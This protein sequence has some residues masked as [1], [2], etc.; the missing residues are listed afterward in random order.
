MSEIK[1]VSKIFEYLLAVKNLNEK[2]IHKITEYEKHWWQ[3]ELLD[4]EGSYIGGTGVKVPISW[5][6]NWCLLSCRG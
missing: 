5:F 2:T 3:D 4:I 6:P 1:N